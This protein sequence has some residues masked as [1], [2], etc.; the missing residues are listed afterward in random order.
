MAQLWAGRRC[1]GGGGSITRIDDFQIQDDEAGMIWTKPVRD[2]WLASR[3]VKLFFSSK[4][5]SGLPVRYVG[6]ASNAPTTLPAA[7]TDKIQT[8]KVPVDPTLGPIAYLHVELVQPAAAADSKFLRVSFRD[9]LPSSW[10]LRF[11]QLD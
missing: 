7:G 10:R 11:S 8:L 2:V 9:D 5:E 1:G 6:A 4:L 3:N